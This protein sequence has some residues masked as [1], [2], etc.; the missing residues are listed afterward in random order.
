MKPYFFLPYEIQQLCDVLI[1]LGFCFSHRADPDD[2]GLFSHGLT[3]IG[4]C[5]GF[6]FSTENGVIMNACI[7]DAE[8]SFC[9]EPKGYD[10]PILRD[11]A[12]NPEKLFLEAKSRLKAVVKTQR[13]KKP[14]QLSL[15]A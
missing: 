8:F 12:A 4:D 2:Y 13:A 11:F 10:D 1:E 9:L 3:V 15:I 5:Y 7:K 14:K 6:R